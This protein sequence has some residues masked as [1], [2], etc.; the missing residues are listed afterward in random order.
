MKAN[1]T[2]KK[3]V[4]IGAG[5]GLVLFAFMGFLPGSFIGGVI[6]LKIAG[7]I[8]GIPLEATL[9]PRLIVGACML[10]GIVIAGMVF[11]VS[12]SL[13]GWAAGYAIGAVRHGRAA[14]IEAGAKGKASK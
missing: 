13:L 1:E 8:V 2:I 6:G 3:A 11:V 14:G 7:S 9:L 4:Y 12:A 5:A 10:F